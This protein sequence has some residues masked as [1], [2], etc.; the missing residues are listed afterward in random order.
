MIK[1]NTAEPTTI[2]QESIDPAISLLRQYCRIIDP[3]VF[4]FKANFI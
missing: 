1:A 3:I 2:S 4:M